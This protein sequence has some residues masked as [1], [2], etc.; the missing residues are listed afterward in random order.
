MDSILD[1][2]YNIPDL[3]N[4]EKQ[5]YDTQD[6]ILQAFLRITVNQKHLHLLKGVPTVTKQY[7]TLKIYLD[8][9]IYSQIFYAV[10]KLQT[11]KFTTF[12]KYAAAYTLCI[13]QICDTEIT[14]LRETIPYLFMAFI[15]FYY[16]S[17]IA[18]VLADTPKS[19]RVS[20]WTLKA[21]TRYFRLKRPTRMLTQTEK[22]PKKAPKR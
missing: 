3:N 20:D 11:L 14:T 1:E 5:L 10:K 15:I 17:A 16:G 21:V 6:T 9:S 8:L 13:N 22:N 4:P 12:E 19:L 2:K 18:N 7:Q